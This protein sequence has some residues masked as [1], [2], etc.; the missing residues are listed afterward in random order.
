MRGVGLALLALLMHG[1]DL[2]TGMILLAIMLG[3]LWAAG[4]PARWFLG[5]GLLAGIGLAALAVGS[6]NRMK[7]IQIWLGNI[8][9]GGP[10]ADPGCFQKV[11]AEYALAD[12]GWWGLGLGESRE[13]WGLLPEP[14]ND[15]ILAI[16]GEELGLPGTFAVLLLVAVL[17]YACFRIVSQAEDTFTRLAAATKPEAI[18]A[19]TF[20]WNGARQPTP[21]ATENDTL[22]G[23]AMML[24][25]LITH[26]APCFHDV[27]TYWSPEAVERVS[28]W[29]PDG[30]AKDGFIHL[31]NS[32]ATALDATGAAK[33]AQGKS[34]MKPFW[35]MTEQDIAAC[36]EMTDW[37]RA[38]YEY[39]R[40]G[41]S[42][43]GGSSSTGPNRSGG[44][45]GSHHNGGGGSHNNGGGG[46]GNSGNNGGGGNSG[47]NG[48]GGD[49]GGDGG[50]APG[51]GGN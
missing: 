9:D 51:L 15:F 25:T 50:E 2:G 36:L 7:R 35:E 13:K 43:G 38:N 27:R 32:G 22:N 3:M 1:R 20:D 24:G 39:F 29:K 49:G 21:F 46:G 31:L 48:G 40:G 11:H 14:H 4:L 8:C 26:T 44:G 42:G 37:E 17:A 33:D 19:S 12:G 41:G 16:I 10:H 18:L 23:V 28:G 34:V 30:L 45:G 47:N 6:A 5:V